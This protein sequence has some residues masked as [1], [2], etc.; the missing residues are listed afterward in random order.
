MKPVLAILDPDLR[1]D[2]P[3]L[4]KAVQIVVKDGLHLLGLKAPEEM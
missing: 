1:H 2:Q 4:V 3:A